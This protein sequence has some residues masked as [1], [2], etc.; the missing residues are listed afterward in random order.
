MPYSHG[1]HLL[2]C[3]QVVSGE[4]ARLLDWDVQNQ[5]RSRSKG[6]VDCVTSAFSSPWYQRVECCHYQRF[7]SFNESLSA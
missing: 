5:F 3:Q 4:L 2:V 1:W 7:T 6:K